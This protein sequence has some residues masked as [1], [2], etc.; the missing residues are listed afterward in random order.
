MVVFSVSTPSTTGYCN[1]RL[2]HSATFLM[3]VLFEKEALHTRRPLKGRSNNDILGICRELLL[4]GGAQ[5]MMVVY[6]RIYRAS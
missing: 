6:W 5:K 3:N 1:Q 2:H 4:E